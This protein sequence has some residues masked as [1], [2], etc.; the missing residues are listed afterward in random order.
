MWNRKHGNKTPVKP[1]QMQVMVKRLESGLDRL[2]EI[3]SGNVKIE[4][5]KAVYDAEPLKLTTDEPKQWQEQRK[6]KTVMKYV[7]ER[8][9]CENPEDYDHWLENLNSDPYLSKRDKDTA[10]TARI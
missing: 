8:L 10:K 9:A 1:F 6:P 4:P 5:T 7:E 3:L 2:D